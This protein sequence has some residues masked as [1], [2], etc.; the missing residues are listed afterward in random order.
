MGVEAPDNVRNVERMKKESNI[1]ANDTSYEVFDILKGPYPMKYLCEKY[2]EYK[3]TNFFKD[4]NDNGDCEPGEIDWIYSGL[5]PHFYDGDSYYVSCCVRDPYDEPGYSTPTISFWIDFV[6]DGFMEHA[7]KL[8]EFR[9]TYPIRSFSQFIAVM[10]KWQDFAKE[11]IK[12]IE[13]HRQAC[14][15]FLSPAPDTIQL[16]Y[17]VK[18]DL[19][20]HIENSIDRILNFKEYKWQTT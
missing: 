11:G 20:K 9:D 10:D 15:E 5:I 2:N 8:E 1:M 19:G 14:E 12:R 3:G 4:F 17:F 13:Q 16:Y 7:P 18:N 6:P